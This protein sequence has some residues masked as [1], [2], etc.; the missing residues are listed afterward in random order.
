[1]TDQAGGTGAQRAGRFRALGDVVDRLSPAPGARPGS[2]GRGWT[3]LEMLAALAVM[4]LLLAL[5]APAWVEMRSRQQLQAH[6]QALLDTLQ[7]A[8]SEALMRQ[9]RVGVCPAL[10]ATTC[11]AQGRWERG[12]LVFEDPLVN[13]RRDPHEPVLQY[14]AGPLGRVAGVQWRGNSTVAHH[15]SYTAQ[16]RAQQPSGAFQAG[17]L[18]LC[19]TA[20][21]PGWALVINALGRVRLQR[22][23]P[24]ECQAAE[25][26]ETV[27]ATDLVDQRA[28]LVDVL[29]AAVNAGKAD[30][31]HLVEF[32]ELTHDQ[33]AD[34]V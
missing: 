32:L 22:M 27:S 11:D 10:D 14:R 2:K 4:G 31:G 34:A 21:M 6:A 5:A 1:M 15:V 25:M 33:L 26:E 9:R 23:Q 20:Q 24:G 12:W 28:E 19:S 17:S 18:R 3:L 16:G 13:A 7:W 29:E 30:V 8:R